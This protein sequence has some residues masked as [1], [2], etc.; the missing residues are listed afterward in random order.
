MVKKVSIVIPV[1]N[2]SENIPLLYQRLTSLLDSCS[3]YEYEILLI[4]DG[5]TDGSWRFIQKL[6]VNDKQI[7]GISLSRNFG[8]QLALTAAYD[9]AQGDAIISMDAD[10]QD[11][12][13]LIFDLLQK[14]EQGFDIVY[15]R[16]INREDSFLKKLTAS[17]YYRFLNSVADVTIP[18]N[19]G[20]FRLI[21]KKVLRALRQCRE[22]SRY[23]RGMVAWTGFKATFV[24]FNRSGRHAGKSGYT[25]KK[26]FK[27]GFDGLTSFSLFPLKIAAFVGMFVVLTGIA[28]FIY[29]SIDAILHNVYYPLF[30]WLTII[31]YIFTGIQMLLLWLISEY[32]GR[33]YDQQ[34]NRPLYLIADVINF[35]TSLPNQ[36]PQTQSFI[37]P[38]KGKI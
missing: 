19:V 21:D 24:D 29:V 28:M 30:K 14:W 27:L 18:R 1:F 17:I 5:S 35:K 8:H 26:M 13:E 22:K 25:W 11:P 34:K 7:K 3:N 2:E 16:R 6:A 23:L 12:P 33:T 15:A 20:D 32:I 9:H 36:L 31:I 10:L 37:S 38:L 4:N